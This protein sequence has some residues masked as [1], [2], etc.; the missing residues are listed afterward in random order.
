MVEGGQGPRRRDRPT[1]REGGGRPGWRRNLPGAPHASR[2]W[3][4][5]HQIN[6]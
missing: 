2:L 6:L 5:A 1:R 4:R 3:A